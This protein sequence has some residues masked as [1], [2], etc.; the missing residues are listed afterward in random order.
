MDNVGVVMRTKDRPLLL[1]R[2]IQ[3]VLNQTIDNIELVVVNDGGDKESTEKLVNEYKKNNKIDIRLIHNPVSLGMEA[4]SNVGLSSLN[5][6]YVTLLDD[7]DT[8]DPRILEK[9]IAELETYNKKMNRIM[10]VCTLTN[11]VYESIFEQQ[12]LLD[13]VVHL[14]EEANLERQDKIINLYTLI[15][16]NLFTNNS[17]LYYYEVLNHIGFYREDLPVLG[18]WEFN[19]R[20]AMQYDILVINDHLAN[21]HK[22]HQVNNVNDNSAPNEHQ[23]YYN[24]LRNQWLRE[25]LKENSSL[26]L[27]ANTSPVFGDLMK[28]QIISLNLQHQMARLLNFIGNNLINK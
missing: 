25:D 26:G 6:K 19:I 4:A 24:V 27:Y 28:N 15:S 7:D 8:W 21:Y 14:E 20:F 3:S 12:I 17:F 16:K 22:R 13:K 10:G 2:A 23:L 5:T 11:I 18:D 1:G 9:Q